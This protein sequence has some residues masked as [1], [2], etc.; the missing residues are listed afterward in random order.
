M[1][2]ATQSTRMTSLN[3]VTQTLNIQFAAEGSTAQCTANYRH[4]TDAT[5]KNKW[6]NNYDILHY[7]TL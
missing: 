3:K 7:I 2:L 6:Y 4:R 5:N 1:P